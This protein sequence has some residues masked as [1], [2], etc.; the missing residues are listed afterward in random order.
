M[1]AALNSLITRRRAKPR[2]LTLDNGTEFC[3]LNFDASDYGRKIELDFIKPGEPVEDAFIEK[4]HGSLLDKS[5]HT[6][7][8][9]GRAE[10]RTLIEEWRAD[11]NELRPHSSPGQLPPAMNM[12][13]GS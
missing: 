6:H 10:A 12:A 9:A 8:L 2:A 4:F 7:W 3:S 1:I 11:Y 5:A 13:G